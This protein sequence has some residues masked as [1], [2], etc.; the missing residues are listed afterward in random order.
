MVYSRKKVPGRSNPPSIPTHIHA[1]SSSVTDLSLPSHFGP[2]PEISALEPG[3]VPAQDLDLDLL[4]ALRK[5]TRACTKHPIAKYISY[6]NLSDNYRAFTTNISKLV[7]PRNI[8][9]ALDEPSWKLTVFEEINALKK[10]GTWEVV[11]LPREKKVVGCK[12]VF[13][14][15]SKADGSVERY[16]AR[17]VAK[18][19]TQTYGIDYQ[20]TFAPVAKINSIRV[21]LSLAVNSNWPL[22]Q[23]DVK[24]AFLNGDL[25]EEVFMSPPPGFE[26][27]FGVGKVCKLKKSLYG[28]KQSPRAW[29]ERFGKVIKHYGYTQSQANHTMFYKH[30][31]ESKVAILIVY[32]DDIVLTGDDCNEL[33]KLKGKLAEEFEI[34]DLGALKYFLGMEFARSKEGIF[35]NQR[36][37]ALD[38]LDETGMLGCKPAE[39]PIEPNVKLQ[40]TKA[41]NVKDRDRY[42][43]LVGRLIYLSHTR[44]NIAFS[45]SMVSQFMHAPG[46]EHFEA[47]YKI[48]RYLKGTP[49]RGL[50]FK[51]QGHLQI[52]TYTDADWAGSIVDRR[53]SAEA[54]FRAV[55]HGICEIMWIRRLLEELKMTGSSP[56]KLYCDNKVAILVAHNPVLHDHTKHVEVDK[57]FIKEKIDNG[58]VCMTYIPTE[59][60]V[61]DVF[62]KGL[63]KRQFDFLVGKLA[64]ED[65]FKPT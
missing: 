37:Y 35:V 41:K 18:G 48:L 23:L 27:S 51:S 52:E 49:S 32:V 16:K 19:F 47:V 59:E 36:K 64:M 33:E 2:S 7:V 34:K 1:S 12:W 28:L 5:G 22:H 40:P 20:E 30:S 62:T 45:V 42:Q 3:L 44:P 14:I 43:R 58:L 15:K 17:L 11:D 31:N 57:H 21:L 60:Q 10:N 63:H 38:L 54:E 25:E 24:N 9:E 39:T 56:M 13:T 8:Q 53:S 29:F 46:P 6:S 26:E 50:L 61:A 55:A 65:I 4:I